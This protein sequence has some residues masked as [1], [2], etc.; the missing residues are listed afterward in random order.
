MTENKINLTAINSRP[1]KLINKQRT[2]NFNI[3]FEG[4]HDMPNVKNALKELRTLGIAITTLGTPE[5]PWFPTKIEDFNHI[6]KRILGEGDGIG[7]VDHPGFR[8]T[9]YRERRNEIMDIAMHYK[10]NEEIP[11][12]QYND[13]E[14]ETWAFCYSRL[15]KM[16]ETNA[17][18]EFNVSIKEFQD[19]VGLCES[20]IP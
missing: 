15:I 4:T 7:E 12:F 2:M 19:N 11:R 18:K 6:G 16:F 13:Q 17:C 5:A 1:P 8:D 20:K 14:N 9:V 10:V 3:D